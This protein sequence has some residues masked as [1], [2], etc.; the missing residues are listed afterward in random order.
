MVGTRSIVTRARATMAV[1]TLEDLQGSMEVVVFPKLFE[2]TGPIWADGSILLVAGRIDHRGDEVSLLADLVTTWDE[3]VV[4]GAEAF[5]RDVA[6]GDRGAFRRRP[7]APGQ[8]ADGNGAGSSDRFERGSGERNGASG[9]GSNGNG[10]NGYAS[11]AKP[12]P[13]PAPSAPRPSVGYVSPL[14]ADATLAAPSVA[15]LP[16]IAPAEPISAHEP[17]NDLGPDPAHDHDDSPSLPDEARRQV[18]AEATAATAPM[19]SANVGQILHVRFGGAPADQLVRA[20][21]TFRQLV[22]ERPGETRV[23]VHIPAPGGS[24]LPMELKQ[25]VAYDADLLAEVQRRL[26][27]GIAS[28]TLQ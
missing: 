16:P 6:A 14:R 20:M 26:G 23:V 15:A 21:E 24:A 7:G 8:S 2:Q 17:S 9:N 1:V 4:K 5:A 28:A 22:R 27:T 11:R 12:D 25:A 18:V 10:S 13:A 19:E 3:A